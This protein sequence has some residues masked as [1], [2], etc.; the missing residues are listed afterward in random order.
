MRPDKE[1]RKQDGIC[2]KCGNKAID[3]RVHCFTHIKYHRNAA[4]GQRIKRLESG[5]CLRCGKGTPIKNS[6]CCESCLE[7]KRR[8]SNRC[9]Y[10]LRIETLNKYGGKCACC[11]EDDTNFLMI[12]HINNDGYKHK[13]GDGRRLAG[14]SLHG[15]AKK[16]GF[17]NSLQVLCSNCNFSKLMNDGACSHTRKLRLVKCRL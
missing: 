8:T 15:W 1:R 11:G 13:A 2:L 5:L 16:R 3:G 10:N 9:N 17:P 14:H 7:E 4:K 12:D 6:Q